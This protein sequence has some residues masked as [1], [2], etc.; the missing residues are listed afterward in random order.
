M[1]KGV[2]I[3]YGMGNLFSVQ[4][5]FEGMGLNVVVSSDLSVIEN[6][7]WYVLPGVGH[8]A[9]AVRN[10]KNSGIWTLLDKKVINDGVPIMGICLGMQLMMIHSEEGNENGF[11]WIN[12]NVKRFNVSDKLKYKIPHVGWNYLNTQ[13]NIL[14]FSIIDKP[15]YFVHSYY[16]DSQDESVIM[17]HTTYDQSFVSIVAH[18]NILGV[19]FH[20]EKSQ[21]Q[22]EMMIQLFIDNFCNV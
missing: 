10:L 22:G 8:F 17:A 15:M 18:K 20:P 14:D 12:G 11:G 16:V 13:S 21:H 4:K 6:A 1:S 3:D 19:Q 2:I 9:A 7:D 5:K